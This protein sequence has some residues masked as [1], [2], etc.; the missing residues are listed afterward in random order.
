MFPLGRSLELSENVCVCEGM[1]PDGGRTGHTEGVQVAWD[2]KVISFADLLA[3]HWTCH[4]P[5][6]G[7]GEREREWDH[8]QEWETER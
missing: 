3:M 4:D 7:T 8:E 5:T 1:A 6:Q 2:P